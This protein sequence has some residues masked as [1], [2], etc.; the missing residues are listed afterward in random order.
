[1][2]HAFPLECPYP[3]IAGTTSPAVA[4]EYILRSGEDVLATKDDMLE[5]VK[6]TAAKPDKIELPWSTHEELFI[7]RPTGSGDARETANGLLFAA[8]AGLLC[9]AG[10]VRGVFAPG[11]CLK[12]SACGKDHFV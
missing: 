4:E 12:G 1:M 8:L 2:H 6:N 5:I 9:T 10:S 3:H 7:A 11:V